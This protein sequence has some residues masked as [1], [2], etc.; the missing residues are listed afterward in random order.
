M[1]VVSVSKAFGFYG[2]DNP[3]SGYILRDFATRDKYVNGVRMPDNAYD[4][5]RVK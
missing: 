2:D 3:D 4:L 5:S 1:S